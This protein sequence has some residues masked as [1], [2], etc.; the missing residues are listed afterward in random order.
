MILRL[1]KTYWQAESLL[2]KRSTILANLPNQSNPK[3]VLKFQSM[4]G[5]F[6]I[7]L[8]PPTTKFISLAKNLPEGL[9]L[10]CTLMIIRRQAEDLV[11]KV[12]ARQK[13]RLRAAGNQVPL[14]DC[15][16]A[17]L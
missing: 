11:V 7:S 12:N 9:L 16:S 17:D 3:F 2:A 5:K 14:P 8:L 1:T 6:E 10:P 4:T 13:Q 15:V